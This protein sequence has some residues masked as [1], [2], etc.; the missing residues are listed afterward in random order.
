[1]KIT[2]D[3]QGRKCRFDNALTPLTADYETMGINVRM[4]NNIEVD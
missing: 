1:L 4:V 2:G 3:A